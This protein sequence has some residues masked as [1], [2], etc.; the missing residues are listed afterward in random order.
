MESFAKICGASMGNK[1]FEIIRPLQARRANQKCFAR[2]FILCPTPLR[3]GWFSH[4]KIQY[5]SSAGTCEDSHDLCLLADRAT[6]LSSTAPRCNYKMLAAD[7]SAQQNEHLVARD[8]QRK[9]F[10]MAKRENTL[11]ILDTGSGKTFIAV[12]LIKHMHA[13]DSPH[14]SETVLR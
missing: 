3:P 14:Q 11:A 5:G 9:L 1:L 7:T 8:Y 4:L 12:M 13:L 2:Q 6:N 10:A